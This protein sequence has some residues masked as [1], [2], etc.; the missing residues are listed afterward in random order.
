MIEGAS[1]KR[2]FDAILNTRMPADTTVRPKR[3]FEES[4]YDGDDELS[5]Y[6]ENE[7]NDEDIGE[8]MQEVSGAETEPG[9]S[10]ETR[11]VSRSPPRKCT[12]KRLRISEELHDQK[13]ARRDIGNISRGKERME[14]SGGSDEEEER[15]KVI[16]Y[17]GGGRNSRR[18]KGKK[19]QR[20]LGYEEFKSHDRNPLSDTDA[21][22]ELSL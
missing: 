2:W 4:P 18:R 3:K 6:D 14:I 19:E 7:E 8:A 16:R 12:W 11:P 5:G 13:D 21:D 20:K 1:L 22:D 10:I 15:P 9:S 17:S